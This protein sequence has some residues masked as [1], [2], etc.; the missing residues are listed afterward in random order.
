MGK[1]SGILICSD[2]DGTLAYRAEIPEANI[3]AIRYFQQNGGLF[4]VIS[5]RSASFF[6]KYSEQIRFDRYIGCVNGTMIYD[7]ENGNIVKQ[8]PISQPQLFR[9]FTLNNYSNWENLRDVMIFGKKS[10]TQIP[11]SSPDFDDRLRWAMSEPVLKT[12]FHGNVPFTEEEMA[13]VRQSL[14]DEFG[15]WRSWALGIEMQD[16]SCDKGIAARHI[17][18]L[19]G[20]KKLI[21]VGDY[22][23]DIPLLRAADVSYVAE[24]HHP[25]LDPIA[26]HIAAPCQV[27]TIASV[28]ESL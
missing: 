13:W 16:V 18:R 21:C 26:H 5:G 11:A 23:N 12:L 10:L 2:F 24:D 4:T 17:A 27:G 28:I 15:V 22:E 7:I 9:D 25:S 20:A 8:H 6:N 14:G 3:E 1:F 19:L